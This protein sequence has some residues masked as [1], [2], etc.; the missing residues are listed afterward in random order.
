[1]QAIIK[2]LKPQKTFYLLGYSFG[3]Q[4]ALEI[5]SVLEEHGKKYTYLIIYIMTYI[6]YNTHSN[7]FFESRLVHCNCIMGH[8]PSTHC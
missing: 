2:K 3:A 5:A 6:I 7:H 1:M 8:G 4:V